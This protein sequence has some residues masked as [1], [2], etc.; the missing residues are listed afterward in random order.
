MRILL[1]FDRFGPY[2]FARARAA[3]A[4]P[5][6]TL[7]TLEFHPDN[8][9]YEW[10]KVSPPEGLLHYQ[11]TRCDELLRDFS[12]EAVAIP[13]WSGAAPRTLLKEC[14]HAAIP[15]V[16]MSESTEWDFPRKRIKEAVKRLKISR[17]DAAFVGGKAHRDY[18]EKL[19][20][21][22]EKVTFGYDTVDNA[23]F[24]PLPEGRPRPADVP[25]KQFFLASARFIEKKNLSGLIRAF[26]EAV[27]TWDLVILG[28]GHLR[29][30]LE[31]LASSLNLSNRVHFPG[32][33]QYDELPNYYAAASAFV[34]ASTTEQ[35]G[36]VVN[37]AL[38]AGLPVIV[39][40]RCGCAHE[41]AEVSFDPADI[42]ALARILTETTQKD[43]A[44]Q[45]S[46]DRIALWDVDRFASGLHEAA[47]IALAQR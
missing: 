19:A 37:E 12:P 6:I 22:P 7:A 23:H 47:T 2:H 4:H 36:L 17:F 39:S 13:G 29:G 31:G 16:V 27:T 21:P 38:A 25:E 41:L 3:A 45:E 14:L 1:A 44:P 11:G 43:H 5:G 28:D 26:S 24:A 10:D 15:T 20:F 35:W 32:F 46:L 40:N 30:E 8:P 42:S 33:K 18:L 34:H 9:E